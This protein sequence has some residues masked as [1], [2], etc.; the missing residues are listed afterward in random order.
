MFQS[1]PYCIDLIEGPYIETRPEVS[2]QAG[3]LEG[4]ATRS[5]LYELSCQREW[6]AVIGVGVCGAGGE[7]VQARQCR[8][9][10]A[11][12]SAGAAAM[13]LVP[14]VLQQTLGVAY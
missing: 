2:E 9:Q 5:A 11:A 1:I 4:C 3:R 6:G 8:A 7:S 10:G 14:G 13:R 12:A